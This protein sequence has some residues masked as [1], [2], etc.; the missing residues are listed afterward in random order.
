MNIKK[1]GINEFISKIG[2][3]KVIC[4]GFG[5]RARSMCDNYK[6]ILNHVEFFVDNDVKKHG[7]NII[8]GQLVNVVSPEHFLALDSYDE[9]VLLITTK[10]FNEIVEQFSDIER[11]NNLD[12]YIYP[13][14]EEEEEVYEAENCEIEHTS[15]YAIPKVIHYCWFG[16]GKKS[17]LHEKCIK[18]WQEKCPDYKIIEWN[19]DNFDIN[20]NTY[21]KEAYECKKYAFVSDFARLYVLYNYGGIYMDTDV[22]VIKPLDEL[23]FVEGFLGFET[24][25]YIS[26]GIMGGVKGNLLIKDQLDAY[27]EIK[28]LDE[29]GKPV[30]L[31][32]VER[33]TKISKE[34]H[35]LIASGHKQTLK[36]GVV[37]YPR[38]YFSPISLIT[39]E[40]HISK[41]TYVVH[42]YDG[43]WFPEDFKVRSKELQKYIENIEYFAGR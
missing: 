41:N 38:T 18:S 27:Q 17:E 31:T 4:F 40:L 9:Y 22:E 23:L 25:F 26:T 34:K 36:Y 37:V 19:E 35:N 11:L 20:M 2:N 24:K 13:L 10:F 32:N 5:I 6:E 15:S 29:V 16:R 43:S 14:M 42:H 33:I 12:V 3:K 39:G 7:M 30:L 1:C 28:F 8:D 21:V